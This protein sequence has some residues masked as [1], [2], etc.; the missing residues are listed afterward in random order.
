LPTRGFSDALH[1]VMGRDVMG[2]D[3]RTPGGDSLDAFRFDGRYSI[4]DSSGAHSHLEHTP[5]HYQRTPA[6]LRDG[7]DDITL[8]ASH[9]ALGGAVVG[10][11]GTET[12]V[13]SGAVL[14]VSK[15]RAHEVVIPW[16]ATTHTLQIPRAALA[17]TARWRCWARAWGRW[18]CGAGGAGGDFSPSGEPQGPGPAI[19]PDF[20]ASS[21]C[22]VIAGSSFYSYFLAKEFRMPLRPFVPLL[23]AAALAATTASAAP[24]ASTYTGV[25]ANSGPDGFDTVLAGQP[26]SVTLVFDNGGSTLVNQTWESS[27]LRCVLW[28]FNT[29]QNVVVAQ[30]LQA[31]PPTG[32]TG[33]V[34]T[35][36][37]GALDGMFSEVY[38]QAV[39]PSAY[40][41]SGFS[42]ALGEV[43]WFINNANAILFSEGRWVDSVPAGVSTAF[44]DWSAP[45]P[46]TGDCAAP[47]PTTPTQPAS[48]PALG[49][50]ALALMAA[51]LGALGWGA[52]RRRA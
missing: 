39:P 35:D 38:A 42:P 11:S 3:L 9:S 20:I 37:G 15:T 12:T 13:P 4:L 28:R 43:R 31:S 5:L 49:H 18:G 22:L 30:D 17:A 51:L 21:A 40:S 44:A 33:A 14:L 2:F 29:A 25:L 24:Y 8:T 48:V 27:N 41:A 32:A 26:Y 10:A 47:A 34:S 19:A 52:A 36:A 7:M 23:A 50:A 1:E 45:V 16:A 46:F 6:L